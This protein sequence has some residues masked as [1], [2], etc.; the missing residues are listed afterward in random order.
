MTDGLARAGA[1]LA[2]AVEVAL[3]AWVERCVTELVLAYTGRRADAAVRAAAADAGRHAVATVMPRLRAL[4]DADIDDQHTTPL[5]VVR[6]AIAFP[7]AVLRSNG[8]PP[9]ERD[10]Y[11]EE[12][13]PDDD[14]GLTPA[15]L[16]DLDPALGPL[17]LVWGAAKAAEFTRR[18][19]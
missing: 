8:V 15:S 17:A 14:Y 5:A 16:A 4:V 3:P 18:R 7:S 2:D 19:R 13:F 10:A 12:A 9:V 1:E 11:A 6:T